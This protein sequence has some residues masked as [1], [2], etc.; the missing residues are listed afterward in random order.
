MFMMRWKYLERALLQ[1]IYDYIPQCEVYPKL[2][3]YTDH[4]LCITPQEIDHWDIMSEER[5]NAIKQRVEGSTSE[6]YLIEALDVGQN[7]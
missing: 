7:E 6:K 4:R 3:P 5:K 2:H 1:I